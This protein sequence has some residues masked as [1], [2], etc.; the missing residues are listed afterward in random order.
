MSLELVDW[1]DTT[2]CTQPSLPLVP[3]VVADD[4]LRLSVGHGVAE[5]LHS[6]A[7]LGESISLF[8]PSDPTVRRDPLEFDS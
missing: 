3:V 5:L 7:C 8:V 4:G 2:V 6:A 1:I